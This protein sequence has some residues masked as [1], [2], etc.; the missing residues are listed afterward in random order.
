MSGN[1]L[2]CDKGVKDPFEFRRE[3]VI[4]LETPQRKR[5]SSLL[6]GRTSWIFSV[7]GRLLLRYDGDVRDPLMWPQERPVS[8]RVVRGLWDS[9]PVGARS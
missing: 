9:C 7:G 1:F 8:M 2:S 5:A 4:S 6:E 3:G